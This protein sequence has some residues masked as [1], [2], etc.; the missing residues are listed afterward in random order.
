MLRL[1]ASEASA[2]A[3]RQAADLRAALGMGRIGG[4]RRT[5]DWRAGDGGRRAASGRSASGVTADRRGG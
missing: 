4:G 3:V 2:R 5:A 1:V